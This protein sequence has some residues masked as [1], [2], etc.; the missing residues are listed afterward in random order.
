MADLWIK[1]KLDVLAGIV[2]FL[3]RGV[4]VQRRSTE[5]VMTLLVDSVSLLDRLEMFGPLVGPTPS[6]SRSVLD[7]CEDELLALVGRKLMELAREVLTVGDLLPR[8]QID[9][10]G[11]G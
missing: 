4:V 6:A 7:C 11:M 2:F 3:Q 1:I 5:N 8:R 9:L 10:V